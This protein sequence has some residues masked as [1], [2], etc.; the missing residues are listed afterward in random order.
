MIVQTLAARDCKAPPTTFYL[1]RRIEA[2][3]ASVNLILAS[4]DAY[5]K[6]DPLLV[7]SLLKHLSLLIEH[8]RPAT[9]TNDFAHK[10]ADLGEQLVDA[11]FPLLTPPAPECHNALMVIGKRAE[12]PDLAARTIQ[13]LYARG[14]T[15]T[16]ATRRI[17]ISLA[18]SRG[19]IELLKD[20]WTVT[21]D[22]A[23]VEQRPVDG[24]DWGAL[25]AGVSS[26]RTR[27][28]VDFLTSEAQRLDWPVPPRSL[29]HLEE[30]VSDGATPQSPSTVPTI[31]TSAALESLTTIL[32][33]AISIMMV[34]AD[35][36]RQKKAQKKAIVSEET[37]MLQ[38][39]EMEGSAGAVDEVPREFGELRRYILRV[40]RV[41]RQIV[42]Y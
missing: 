22:A 28:A 11:I 39:P 38:E 10:I 42:Q 6:F 25:I 27:E 8:T 1:G 15:A 14:G 36:Q 35:L 17:M 41:S 20:T 12:Y 2:F 13:K 26:L 40:R 7:A 29:A 16:D 33:N 9:S 3:S 30:L 34:Q 18:G 31:D 4:Y 24:K 21:L 5:R 37:D 32:T 19:D 23:T